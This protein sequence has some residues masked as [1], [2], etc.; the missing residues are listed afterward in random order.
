MANSHTNLASRA[1]GATVVAA[2]DESFGEKENLVLDRPCHFIPGHFGNKGEIVDGWETRR[3]GGPGEDWAII[4]LGAAGIV[5]EIDV[6]TTS[7]SGNFPERCRI[8]ACGVERYPSPTE[9]AAARWRTIV[10]WSMLQGDRHNTLAV[11]SGER[12]THL[13]L[14]TSPDGGVARL[15]ANGSA[16]PDPVQVDGL[17]VD[18]AGRALGGIV[19]AW[20]DDFYSD[21]TSL[22]HP[23]SAVNMGEGWETKRR[24]GEGHD[25]A[26]LRLAATGRIRLLELDTSYY[27][28]NASKRFAIHTALANHTPAPDSDQWDELLPESRL[29]PDTVQLYPISGIEANY[30][31]ID[32]FPDG[33]LSRLRVLGTVTGHARE[34][35]GRDWFNALPPEQAAEVLQDRT[36]ISRPAAEELAASRPI[37]EHSLSSASPRVRDLIDGPTLPPL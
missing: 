6:D 8:D 1:L 11:D 30:L 29:Q 33:G 7:F 18:L 26:V 21:A 32:L 16:V 4:R 10:D 17:S 3:R 36:G 37:R 35:L 22:N 13:R 19:E 28:C 2:S 23:K 14:V 31:R 25:W 12:Y 5:N 24:R 9:L 15:R 20:S 34:S 27:V